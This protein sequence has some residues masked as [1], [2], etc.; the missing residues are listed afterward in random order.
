MIWREKEYHQSS[1]LQK[2]RTS[3]L[4]HPNNIQKFEEVNSL[5]KQ[6][7]HSF[8]NRN[9]VQIPKNSVIILSL[10]SVEHIFMWDLLEFT[11]GR[12]HGWQFEE[13]FL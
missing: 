13:R 1:T 5:T 10:P 8:Q 11:E 9:N 2:L 6:F 4:L 3:L 7:S 12:L